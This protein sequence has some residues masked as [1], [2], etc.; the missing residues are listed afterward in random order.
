MGVLYYSLFRSY[1]VSCE[2]EDIAPTFEGFIDRH[3]KAIR[4]KVEGQEDDQFEVWS[5][6]FFASA[7]EYGIKATKGKASKAWNL[8]V[9]KTR[10]TG[11]SRKRKAA[12]ANNVLAN[13]NIS[14]Y[15]QQEFVFNRHDIA[16]STA[17]FRQQSLDL[18]S[19]PNDGFM[20]NMN[21]LLAIHFI[22]KLT[23]PVDA[24]LAACFDVAVLEALRRH[25]RTTVFGKPSRFNSTIALQLRDLTNDFQDDDDEEK[26]RASI[27]EIAKR[28]EGPS[29]R[30][31]QAL[32]NLIDKM[33][34]KKKTLGEKKV[35]D[36]L[37]SVWSSLFKKNKYYDPHKFDNTLFSST[38][39]LAACRPDY[40]V[41]VDEGVQ[42]INCIGEVKPD[43][44]SPTMVSL[45]TFRLGL[46]SLGLMEK[47]NLKSVLSFQAVGLT[48]TFF[49]YSWHMGQYYM[50]EVEKITFPST[51]GEYCSFVRNIDALLNV[52]TLFDEHCVVQDNKEDRTTNILPYLQM[53]EMFGL[54]SNTSA[55]TAQ[56]ACPSSS[57][58]FSSS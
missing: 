50:V 51:Y 52:A 47:Y 58:P 1:F 56:S 41:E 49:L 48:V 11:T 53:K 26:L 35:E 22:T 29:R 24:E 39:P 45:D 25:F 42:L 33:T 2:Q 34:V 32:S 15:E 21:K 36:I 20:N 7:K 55:K 46:F 10:S 30:T 44:A 4:S 31:I 13:F 40:A 9:L 16:A 28:V 19:K 8:L 5:K 43:Y 27:N 23:K 54:S 3:C 12:Q 17:A 37:E 38:H 14:Q 6:L 57:R 18:L